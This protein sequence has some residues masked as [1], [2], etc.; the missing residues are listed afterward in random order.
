MKPLRIRIVGGSLAGLF[1]GVLLQQEGHDVRIYERSVHGLGG[2]GAGLVPQQEV[3][4]MLRLIGCD[5]VARIGV[6]ATERIYL[7]AHGRVAQASA[8]PQMQVSWDVLYEAVVSR[9]DGHRYALGRQVERV[10]DGEYG[11]TIHFTDRSQEDADLVIGADG[12]GSVVRNAINPHHHENHYA[13]Y[14]AWRG[15]I[16]ETAL[17]RDARILLDRF[18]FYVAPGAQALGY[19][20]PGPKGEL[21]KGDRRYNWVWYRKVPPASLASLFTDKAGRTSAFSLARGGLSDERLDALHRDAFDALPSP[22]A[23]AVN[24]EQSPSIQGIFDYE[25][26]RM[27]GQSIALIGDAAFVVRPHT[28]MGVAKAAGDVMALQ[29]HLAREVELYPALSGFARE[30]MQTGRE[31]AAYGRQLGASAL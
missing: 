20:V 28:A 12:L 24:A 11:A 2:R 17:P 15:L 30:R 31:I 29:R 9:L 18:A 4:Q 27:V 16:P 7:D 13:G 5:E 26:P 21:G 8:M 1:A 3:F 10:A 19:L 25:A 14:V 22:F 23:L 6:L